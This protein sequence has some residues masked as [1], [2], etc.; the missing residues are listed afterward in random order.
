MNKSG[1]KDLHYNPSLVSQIDQF[2]VHLMLVKLRRSVRGLFVRF[3]FIVDK[4]FVSKVPYRVPQVP[5]Q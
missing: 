1:I 2:E 4:S 3:V 5:T